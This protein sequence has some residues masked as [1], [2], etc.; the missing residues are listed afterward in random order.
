YD[1]LSPWSVR[2]TSAQLEAAYPTVGRFRALRI[3]RDGLGEFG[4]RAVAVTVV[5]SASS[6]TVSGS[7]FRSTLGLRSTLF[8]VTPDSTATMPRDFSGDSTADLLAT[9]AGGRL[10]RWNG[11]D[12]GGF[13]SAVSVG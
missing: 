13:A 5:G 1:R 4:G 8:S 7:S 2:L 6:L 11:N 10:Y 9:H 12:A 3:E